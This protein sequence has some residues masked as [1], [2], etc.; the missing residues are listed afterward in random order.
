MDLSVSIIDHE[1]IEPEVAKPVPQ[2]TKE[3]AKP[4]RLSDGAVVGGNEWNMM[5]HFF[6]HDEFHEEEHFKHLS[7]LSRFIVRSLEIERFLGK[8]N[9]GKYGLKSQKPLL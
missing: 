6:M 3:E 2:E 5:K 8:L 7:E 9:R 1:M 4:N